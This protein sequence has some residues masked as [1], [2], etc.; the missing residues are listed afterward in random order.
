MDTHDGT[1]TPDAET[2]GT[3]SSPQ[4]D[5]DARPADP[6]EPTADDEAAAE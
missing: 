3:G 2:P 1:S 5:G 4:G 6:T